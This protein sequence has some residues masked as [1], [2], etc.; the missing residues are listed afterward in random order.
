MRDIDVPKDWGIS[1]KVLGTQLRF[2]ENLSIAQATVL[3]PRDNLQ[4]ISTKV[5]AP[6]WRTAA[7]KKGKL[8]KEADGKKSL[9]LLKIFHPKISL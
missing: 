6:D 9:R 4:D 2:A 1:F 3:K 7:K 8:P 5:E